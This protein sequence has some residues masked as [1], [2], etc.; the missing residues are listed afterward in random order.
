MEE[1]RKSIVRFRKNQQHLGL[2]GIDKTENFDIETDFFSPAKNRAA[3]QSSVLPLYIKRKQAQDMETQTDVD[4][5]NFSRMSHQNQA[6]AIHLRGNYDQSQI[7]SQINM[8]SRM[9]YDSVG[10]QSRKSVGKESRTLNP[11]Q[12]KILNARKHIR[13]STANPNVF[14]NRTLSNF[15]TSRLNNVN[16]K[17]YDDPMR[18]TFQISPIRERPIMNDKIISYPAIKEE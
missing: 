7:S 4:M 11:D 3:E 8:K 17:K 12:I 5:Q 2:G 18:K 6:P 1:T 10:S 16:E 15:N 13:N 14:N 9:N